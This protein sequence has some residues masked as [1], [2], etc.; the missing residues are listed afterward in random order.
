MDNTKANKNREGSNKEDEVKEEA[1]EIKL[2]NEIKIKQSYQWQS[3]KS[4]I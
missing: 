1:L 4:Q 3:G 2:I